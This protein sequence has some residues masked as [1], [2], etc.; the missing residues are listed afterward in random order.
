MRTITP[1][2]F[3]AGAPHTGSFAGT[4]L[5]AGIGALTLLA[6]PWF[7]RG[8]VAVDRW[9]MR[10][11]LGPGELAQRVRIWRRPGRWRWTTRRRCCAGWSGTSTTGRR[12][13]WSRWR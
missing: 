5:A 10:A 6:A 3:G 4:F 1:F 7:T 11:L 13:D 9:L 2:P 8:V 12:S